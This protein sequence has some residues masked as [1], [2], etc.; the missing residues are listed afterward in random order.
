MEN[1]LS[2]TGEVPLADPSAS[3]VASEEKQNQARKGPCTIGM[4]MPYKQTDA[5]GACLGQK[6]EKGVTSQCNFAVVA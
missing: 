4:K 6:H 3:Q 5:W 1:P 2:V